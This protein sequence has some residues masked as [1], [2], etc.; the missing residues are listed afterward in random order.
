LKIPV[1]GIVDTNND[2]DN[3]DYIIPANDDSMR[4][5][6][7]YVRSVADAILDAQNAN[8]VG[9][10]SAIEFVDVAGADKDSAGS[11]N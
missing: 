8:T 5:V 11:V 4:A 2:P 3:I 7:I 1:F 9:S 6:N 10:V